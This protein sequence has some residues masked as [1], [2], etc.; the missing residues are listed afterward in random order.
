MA[1]EINLIRDEPTLKTALLTL[2]SM[3]TSGVS[4]LIKIEFQFGK[5]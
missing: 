5:E 3:V 1:L 4:A 2:N